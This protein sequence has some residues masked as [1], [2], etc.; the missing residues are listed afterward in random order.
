MPRRMLA[1]ALMVVL[2]ACGAGD[3]TSDGAITSTTGPQVASQGGGDA[4]DVDVCSLLTVDEMARLGVEVEPPE[5]EDD[6]GKTVVQ[7]CTFWVAG[8]VTVTPVMTFDEYYSDANFAD[9]FEISEF[10]GS[11]RWAGTAVDPDTGLVFSM[12]SGGS[13]AVVAIT[14]WVEIVPGSPEEGVLKELLSLATSR[15]DG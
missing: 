8:S 5:G 6:L 9:M 3:E 2:S 7:Q 12:A 1:M 13:R 4:I 14:P 10:S 11:G 15:L